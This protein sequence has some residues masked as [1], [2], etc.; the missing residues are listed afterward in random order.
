MP[1]RHRRRHSPPARYRVETDGPTA[2]VETSQ[3]PPE[4]SPVES[5]GDA[6]SV[7]DKPYYVNLSSEGESPSPREGESP[8]PGPAHPL[9]RSHRGNYCP[10]SNLVQNSDL[11]RRNLYYFGTFRLTLRL[12][13][14]TV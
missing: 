11:F 2:R 13:D 1:H 10:S 7:S 6:F 4:P 9:G 14:Y 8:R 3:P 12:R 5:N